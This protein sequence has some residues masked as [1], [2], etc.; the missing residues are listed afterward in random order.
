MKVFV[1][2]KLCKPTRAFQLLTNFFFGLLILLASC[3]NKVPKSTHL[4]DVEERMLKL[5][6]LQEQ[7]S[8]WSDAAIAEREE[9]LFNLLQHPELQKNQKALDA[10]RAALDFLPFLEENIAPMVSETQYIIDQLQALHHELKNNQ[11]TAEQADKFVQ[12]EALATEK[13]LQKFDYFSNRW[14]AHQLL[15]ETLQMEL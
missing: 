8:S 13:L 10:L 2:Q 9:Q 12:D 15:I 6:D 11:L 3:Q 1:S 4:L 14:H 7:L 5:E